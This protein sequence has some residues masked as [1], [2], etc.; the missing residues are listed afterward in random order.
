M[1]ACNVTFGGK[2]SLTWAC[3]CALLNASCAFVVPG[4][5]AN[6]GVTIEGAGNMPNP[7]L[8]WSTGVGVRND[9]GMAIPGGG[10]SPSCVGWIPRG[11]N[12]CI[13]GAKVCKDGIVGRIAGCVK[14]ELNFDS[15]KHKL[16]LNKP[17]VYIFILF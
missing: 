14:V 13:T 4:V 1:C 11:P 15:P 7:G 12:V 9:V 17:N 8:P 5:C 2:C 3:S 16:K 10:T 6:I